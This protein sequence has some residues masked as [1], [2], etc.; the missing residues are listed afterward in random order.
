MSEKKQPNILFLFSDEHNFRFMG[1]VSEEEGG[2][3]V[4]TPNFDKL[5]SQGTVFKNAYCQ[6]PLC[7]PS[8]IC[9]LSGREVRNAGAWNNKT[10]M[11][12]D[13]P[14]IP[15]ILGTAGYTTCLV[16]KMHFG[17]SLQF[18]GFQHRPYGD[19]TGN[20]GHQEDPLINLIEKRKGD[21]LNVLAS[22]TRDA[23]VTEIPESRLQEEVVAQESIAFLREHENANPDKPWFLCASFSRPHF[24]LTSAKRFIDRY[25][26]EGVTEP[27]APAAGDA[28][29]HP[30]SVGMRK[31]FNV[32]RISHDEMMWA[33]ACYFACVT[34]ID[35]IIG[36]LLV[37]LEASGLLENTVI[38]Y[39][40]D[41]GEMAGEHGT[42]WKN[43]WYEACT[44]IPMIVSLPEQ[45]NGTQPA[46]EV[47]EA[48][49]LYDLFPTFCGLAD[50]DVP[51]DVQ[52]GLDGVD[53]T[54]VLQGNA[55]APDR[56]VVCDNLIPRWGEGTEF[57]AIRQGQYKYVCFRNAEPLFF[58][59]ANDQNEQRNL[60]GKAT[61]EAAAML[62]QLQA[63]AAETLD[64][65]AAA[66]ERIE[67]S[68]RLNA[69]YP[70]DLE[71]KSMLNQ[72]IMPNGQL[73]EADDTL[74]TP[75]VLA[76]NPAD[77]FPDWPQFA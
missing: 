43:G 61:G 16:G 36:D 51:D 30:M 35:Q 49:G 9:M 64:F 71:K 47:E 53:L 2:E 6:M 74:Y 55:A 38:I 73:V 52:A 42:W 21:N 12:P 50:V 59:L 72:F 46:Q 17:G 40:T 24:P 76:E 23:G 33:R 65:E 54:G 58:D 44:H 11:D 56:P 7:T 29:D 13:L 77:V 60:I 39:S 70:L 5:A 22:R 14:T 10:V 28:Y 67:S 25:W 18:N 63:Y 41:H 3:P 4:H 19:I 69:A 8:R 62:A 32:D 57:R 48:V 27:I 66:Q 75:T 34:H 37:R 20:T 31:G 1:H 15:K 45:R 68:E 26:P